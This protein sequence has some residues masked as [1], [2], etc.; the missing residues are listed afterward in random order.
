MYVSVF[1]QFNGGREKH[2]YDSNNI[3]MLTFILLCTSSG[4]KSKKDTELLE[5]PKE[6]CEELLKGLK[7]KTHVEHLYNLACLAW[8]KTGSGEASWLFTT[9]S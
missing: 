3:G 5:C 1:V 9:S 7:R 6:A 4:T 8:R 2:I